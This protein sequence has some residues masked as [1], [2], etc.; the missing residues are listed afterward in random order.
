VHFAT[1]GFPDA[2][3]LGRSGLL[4]TPS[5]S[6]GDDGLLQAREVVDLEV[7]SDLVVL[8]GCTTGGVRLVPGEGLLGLPQALLQAGAPTVVMSL[9]AVRDRAA[10][11]FM[12][13]FYAALARGLDAGG[14]LRSAKLDLLASDDPRLRHPST[15]APFVLFGVAD[16]ALPAPSRLRALRGPAAGVALLGLG[17]A[18]WALSRRRA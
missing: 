11:R 6:D 5:P 17:I 14:A 13:R 10:E 8:S 4:L 1:H 15:W 9:W 3:S 18:F 16:R 7:R 12:E 2:E